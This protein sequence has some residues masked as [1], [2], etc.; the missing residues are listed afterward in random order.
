MGA[1]RFAGMLL[2]VT[3]LAAWSAPG[4]QPQ[5]LVDA[6]RAQIGVTVRYDPSYARLSF[7]GGDVPIE[8]GVCTDVV[9]RAY[10]QLGADLQLLVHRDMAAHWRAYPNPWGMKKPDTNIDHRRVPNLETYFAR[11]GTALP[12]TRVASDYRPGDIVTWRLP[13]NLPHI[14]IVA[15]ARSA[16]GT[17]LVIHNIGGG[18]KM[19]DRLFEFSI[20][21]HYR[22]AVQD[23]SERGVRR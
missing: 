2:M 1:R 17:P 12:V 9:V 16:S 23:T 22:Y 13:G 8:R 5:A 18:A 20:K 21:G 14:G 6:A 19:D 4:G 3:S 7:P 10:R 11:H 15:D